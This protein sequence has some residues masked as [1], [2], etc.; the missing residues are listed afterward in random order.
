MTYSVITTISGDGS[1]Y[2]TLHAALLAHTDGSVPGL[3]LHLATT[4]ETGVHITEV[5]ATKEA[6][7]R[8]NHE[9]LWPLAAQVLGDRASTTL[10]SKREFTPRG[11]VIP[12]AEHTLAN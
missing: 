8:C 10:V 1:D 6:F 11:L 2:D 9:I 5:W 4:T 3:I 12:A 7:E